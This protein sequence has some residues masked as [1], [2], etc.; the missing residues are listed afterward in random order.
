[1]SV[2]CHWCWDKLPAL[3]EHLRRAGYPASRVL[4]V[5]GLDGELSTGRRAALTALGR[6]ITEPAR[7]PVATAFQAYSTP[8]YV[9]VREGVIAAWT[10]DADRL[11]APAPAP[12]AV[13]AP[14]R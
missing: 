11:P 2:R 14:A 1:M 6:V 13:A 5:V 9:L 8:S 3:R 7:G 10:S 4:L 12:A